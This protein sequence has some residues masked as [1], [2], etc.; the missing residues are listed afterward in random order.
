LAKQS[1]S[2]QEA[3]FYIIKR[4]KRE[5]GREY[6]RGNPEIFLNSTL[7]SIIRTTLVFYEDFLADKGLMKRRCLKRRSFRKAKDG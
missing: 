5:L 4:F 1:F 7:D 3:I 6:Q 2:H